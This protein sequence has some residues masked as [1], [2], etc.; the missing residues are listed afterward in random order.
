M[1]KE[2]HILHQCSHDSLGDS[3]QSRPLTSTR[4]AV[5]AEMGRNDMLEGRHAF[6]FADNG[7]P[8]KVRVLGCG[9][10]S[11]MATANIQ[12]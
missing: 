8:S 1:A 5:P 12:G 6:V 10:C 3:I 11:R 7:K 4:H 2:E 9:R